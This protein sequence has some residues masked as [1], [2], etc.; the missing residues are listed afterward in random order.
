MGKGYERIYLISNILLLILFLSPILTFGD[1][2]RI[3][4]PLFGDVWLSNQTYTIKWIN[5]YSSEKVCIEL[6]RGNQYFATIAA[7]FDNSGSYNW[8]VPIE[9]NTGQDYRIKILDPNDPTKYCY[10][11]PFWILGKIPEPENGRPKSFRNNSWRIDLVDGGNVGYYTSIA[12]DTAGHPHISYYDLDNN[13]LKHAW[14]NGSAWQNEIVDAGGNVGTWTS[15]AIDSMNRIHISYCDESN[16]DLKYAR[17]DSATAQWLS[18]TV[19]ATGNRGE[20]TSIALES[21]GTPHIS[22]IYG[23]AGDVMHAWWTGSRWASECADDERDCGRYSAIDLDNTGLPHIA[24]HD[25]TWNRE[26]AK[27]AYYTTQWNREWIVETWPSGLY[28]SITVDKANFPPQ[29]KHV[30]F[31]GLAHCTYARRT[32]SWNLE[33]VE[34]YAGTLYI[35]GTSIK[36]DSL[37]RPHVAYYCASSRVSGHLK[38]AYRETSG[39]MLETVDDSGSVGGFCSLVLDDHDSPHMSYVDYDHGELRYATRV[40]TALKENRTNPKRR[41][42]F[43]IMPNPTTVNRALIKYELPLTGDVHISVYNSIGKLIRT[44]TKYNQDSGT[45]TI[46]WNS[47]DNNGA[48]VPNGIYF[49]KFRTEGYTQ[50]RRL[51]LF[52]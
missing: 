32:V 17:K 8:C 52:R 44:L 35:A 28:N 36:I 12:L 45:H 6:C 34:P 33:P 24:H 20:Y 42:L 14:W 15:I 26:Y 43:E 4:N 51:I 38:Y 40:G 46:T 10:S 13:D 27:H 29:Q 50:T 25:Y 39:W 18:Q 5:G 37:N 1:E 21:N 30:S 22:Y 16:R 48:D 49:L 41:F 19:D 2:I 7:E 23:G 3:E 9:L 11:E 31:Q 47:K